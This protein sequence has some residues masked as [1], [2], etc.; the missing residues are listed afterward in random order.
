M[1][2]DELTEAIHG[3]QP[4]LPVRLHLSN[5]ATYDVTHPDGIMIGGGVAAI[6]VGDRIAMVAIAHINEV[7][8]VP[9]HTTH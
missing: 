7:V 4:F 1:N 9:V 5:G 8:P 3:R 2:H 6:S